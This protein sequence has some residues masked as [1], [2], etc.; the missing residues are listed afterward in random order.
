MSEWA[1]W[2]IVVGGMVVT[3]GTRL[4]FIVLVPPERMPNLLRRGLRYVPPA[5]LAALILPDLVQPGGA[6]DLSLH[7][8]RLVAGAIAAL[9]AWRFRNTWI[10]IAAGMLALWLLT[11]G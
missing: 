5:I 8:E 1:L 6:L 4:S 3:Y 10:T 9:A 2:G 7:N 11:M